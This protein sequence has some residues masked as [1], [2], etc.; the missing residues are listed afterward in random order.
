MFAGVSDLLFIQLI[1][2][3]LKSLAMTTFGGFFVCSV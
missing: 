2:G 3:R 1:S